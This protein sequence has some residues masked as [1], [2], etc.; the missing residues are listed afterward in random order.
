MRCQEAELHGGDCSLWS[1]QQR[2]GFGELFHR[3]QPV[4]RPRRERT[5]KTSRLILLAFLTTEGRA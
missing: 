3:L 5:R 4:V 2:F 1:G